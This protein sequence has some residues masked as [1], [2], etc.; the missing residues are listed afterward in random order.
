MFTPRA[1]VAFAVVPPALLVQVTMLNRLPLPGAAPNLVLVV[2]VALALRNERAFG[3][4]TGFWV[5]LAADLVPPAD[6]AVGRLALVL[7]LAGWL[8]AELGEHLGEET[9][10]TAA[11]PVLV[12]ALVAAAAG[13][14][15]AGVG[16][17]LGDPRIS[18]WA[19]AGAVP[20][21]VLYDVVLAPFVLPGVTAL[22]R[23][24]DREG[25]FR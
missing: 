3:M 2:V 25:V 10:R 17:L 21:A 1:L 24:V 5:G 22:A 15:D 19:V 20:T 14:L 6:H 23:W 11:A 9:D 7:A 13:L 16:A 4:L 18:W 12:V 8:A